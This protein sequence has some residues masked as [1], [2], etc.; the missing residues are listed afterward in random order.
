MTCKRLSL[1]LALSAVLTLTSAHAQDNWNGGTGNW[2]NGSDWSAG[3]PGAGNDVVI[4]SGG[5]DSVTLD[6]SPTINSLTLGGVYQGNYYSQL[7]D[8]RVAQT[9]TITNAMNIGQTGV[10]YL[11]GGTTVSVGADS[12]NA[13]SIF[14][15]KGSTVSINGNFDNQNEIIT[16]GGGSQF[17]VIGTLTNQI[18]FELTGAGDSATVGSIMNTGDVN[19]GPGATLNLTNQAGGIQDVPKFSSWEIYG[20]FEVG[21]VADTAFASLTSIE[22]GLDLLDGQTRNITPIGGTLTISNSG[23]FVIGNGTT[24]SITGN[25]TNNGVFELGG[26]GGV[27]NVGT[28]VNDGFLS[29][30]T[31]ATLN[32]ATQL[33]V[34]DIP[35]SSVYDVWGTLNAGSKNAFASLTSIE[36]GLVLGNGQTTNTTPIGGTLTI[37]NYGNYL[38]NL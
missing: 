15:Y 30:G 37:S 2:S 21:G 17:N 18:E 7:T 34:T 33:N 32:V 25:L 9:L 13:G 22:G 26:S 29:I 4:Y 16:G 23:S 27:A 31:G 38:G 35:S 28:L 6:T 24:V 14:L 10:L 1:A 12:S 8:G 11:T 5:N 36:G 3:L 19:I 20:N